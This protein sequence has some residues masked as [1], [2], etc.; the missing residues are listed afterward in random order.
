MGWV[1]RHCEEEV[2]SLTGTD[3]EDLLATALLTHL[4]VLARAVYYHCSRV[5]RYPLGENL[6]VL[7]HLLYSDIDANC[8]K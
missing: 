3:A 6:Q 2:L 1:L 4:E 8:S 5:N 7:E